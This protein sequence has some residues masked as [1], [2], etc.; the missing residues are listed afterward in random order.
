MASGGNK[1]KARKQ[2]ALALA[3]L[4]YDIFQE[5]QAGAK[6]TVGQ[7]NAQQSSGN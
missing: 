6:M 4:I 5:Q 3:Q 2:D 1:R 7:N